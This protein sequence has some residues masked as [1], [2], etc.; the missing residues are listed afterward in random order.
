MPNI[1]PTS[2]VKLE[3][4]MRNEKCDIGTLASTIKNKDEF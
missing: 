4:F 1:K 2:I 3:K